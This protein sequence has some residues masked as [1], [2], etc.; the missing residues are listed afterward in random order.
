MKTVMSTPSQVDVSTH[1]DESLG[2]TSRAAVEAADDVHCKRHGPH[3]SC[4]KE[5][6][7]SL[8][9]SS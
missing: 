7:H 8:K 6:E 4:R 2:A 5:E 1:P 3:M 9:T